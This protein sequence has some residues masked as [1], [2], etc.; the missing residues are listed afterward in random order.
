MDVFVL[1]IYL[2]LV[3]YSINI[4]WL[5]VGFTKVKKFSYKQVDPKTTFSI[6]VPFRNENENLPNLL[7]SFK[8]INY[9]SYLFEVI[10]VDDDSDVKFEVLDYN[11]KIV[12]IDTIRKSDAPK[13]DAINTAI[14]IAQNDWIITTDADCIVN[15]EWLTIY[16]AFIQENKPKMVASGVLFNPIKNFLQ[17]FQYLDLL[18]LQGTTIGSFGNSQAFMCN[19]AN[20]CYLKSFFEDLKGFEGNEKIASGD[21]VFLLQKAIKKDLKRVYFLKNKKATV[22]TKTEPTFKRLFYQRVRWASKTGNYQSIYS[23]QLGLSV[24]LMNFVLILLVCSSLFFGF[25][26]KLLIMVLAIKSLVDYVLFRISSQYFEKP[27]RF[28]ILSI[29]IYA[30]FSSFVVIYSLFGQYSWKGRTFMK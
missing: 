19:G 25:G 12:L 8:K 17:N 1:I 3:G 20:F 30:F 28:L 5:C 27:L 2:I 11:Y 16:D 4:F 18:S 24:F 21:D 6:I 14:A 13:K 7:A 23:K 22:Y 9:P 26:G 10:L 15:K 29:F